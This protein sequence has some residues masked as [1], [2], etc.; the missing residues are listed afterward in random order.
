MVK[1][2]V[3][4]SEIINDFDSFLIDIWGVL[5]DGH[6]AYDGAIETLKALRQAGKS[7]V[8]ISNAPRPASE[9]PLVLRRLGILDELYDGIMTS[10]QLVWQN[11]HDRRD[12][13]YRQLGEKIFLL[14]PMKD[15][16]M[17][18]NI[19]GQAVTTIAEAE[20]ILATGVDF[21]EVANDYRSLLAEAAARQLPMICAN[22]DLIVIHNGQRLEC[23]GMLA[24]LYSELGGEVRYQGKPFK[25]IYTAA[26]GL[27]AKKTRPA[28]RVLAIGDSIDT[29]M[30]GANNASL[31]CL[32]IAGGIHGAELLE[33]APASRKINLELLNKL[34]QQKNA[35]IDFVLERLVF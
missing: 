16:K 23:A 10:G 30:R 14:G 5:H 25:E 33:A 26:L 28:G 4:I 34:Q 9:V 31:P 3:G 35:N 18:E 22:P 19:I 12:P 20:V 8:L 29:D 27:M 15:S 13:W 32:F 17:V 6:R 24:K 7:I 11:L 1:P 21:H 2:L